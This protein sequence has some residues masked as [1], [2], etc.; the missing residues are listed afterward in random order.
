MVLMDYRSPRPCRD[1]LRTQQCIF[2][3]LAFVFKFS[4][5]VACTYLDQLTYVCS[6]RAFDVQNDVIRWSKS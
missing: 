3:K 4:N 2:R 1:L 6:L 5:V